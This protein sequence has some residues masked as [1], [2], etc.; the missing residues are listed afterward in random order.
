MLT[1]LPKCT[2]FFHRVKKI[3]DS[4]TGVFSG[5]FISSLPTNPI[6]GCDEV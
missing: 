2:K 6:F 3:I 5:A 1:Y 4:H